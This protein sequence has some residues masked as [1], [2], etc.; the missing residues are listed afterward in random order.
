[1]GWGGLGG[2]SEG[3]WRK[4]P[5]LQANQL[6]LILVPLQEE[7]LG[8]C[9]STSLSSQGLPTMDIAPSSGAHSRSSKTTGSYGI[10]GKRWTRG[11]GS[12]ILESAEDAGET[13]RDMLSKVA[14]ALGVQVSPYEGDDVKL[15]I[16][17]WGILKSLDK[18]FLYGS[19]NCRGR[20][21]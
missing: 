8:R 5:I 21:P 9:T 3:S 2:D 18:S 6:A 14:S 12:Q 4:L 10:L 13:S 15:D 19:G 16:H 11:G 1:M 17:T 7:P 20:R